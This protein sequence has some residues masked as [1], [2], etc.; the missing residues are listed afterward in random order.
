MR[1]ADIALDSSPHV[2][3]LFP[4]IKLLD[5]A[6]VVICM[7]QDDISDAY[8]PFGRNNMLEV[9]FLAAHY[10]QMTSEVSMQALYNFITC[11]A[12]KALGIKEF[13]LSVG[14]QAHLVILN[15]PS[16][17]EALRYHEEPLYTISH[18]KLVDKEAMR[19]V[20]IGS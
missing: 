5:Q 20:A 19:T 6:G 14:N 3:P 8:Y 17:L 11:N 18:G 2:A 7:G 13:G 1:K 4:N 16:I 9:A 10:Q 15:Q 12:A